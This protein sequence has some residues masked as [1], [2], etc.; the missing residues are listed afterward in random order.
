MLSYTDITHKFYG[1]FSLSKSAGDEILESIIDPSDPGSAVAYSQMAKMM[2]KAIRIAGP[3]GNI[4]QEF[5]KLV[6][7]LPGTKY[8]L[9]YLGL[10]LL[11]TVHFMLIE[12]T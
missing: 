6:K 9:H 3:D 7:A 8:Q 5:E 10:K 2:R 11:S 1:N 12:N 4:T